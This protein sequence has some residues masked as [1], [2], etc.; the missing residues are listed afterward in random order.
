MVPCEMN[1]AINC[2]RCDVGLRKFS[3]YARYPFAKVR[4][5]G[6]R[7]DLN[8]V[9]SAQSIF[10]YLFLREYYRRKLGML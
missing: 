3:P 5:V 7:A 8:P 10:K 1:V 9:E 6:F 2:Q 4:D